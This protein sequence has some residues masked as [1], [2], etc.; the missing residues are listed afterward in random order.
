MNKVM[1]VRDDI[2]QL[3]NDIRRVFLV[4]QFIEFIDFSLSHQSTDQ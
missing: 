3:I 1:C 4:D 2:N